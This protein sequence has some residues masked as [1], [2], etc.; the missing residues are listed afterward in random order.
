MPVAIAF[1]GTDVVFSPAVAAALR[2]TDLRT[3]EEVS[4]MGAG[5]GGSEE[6]EAKP[7]VAEDPPAALF[8]LGAVLDAPTLGCSIQA[9]S[10][11]GSRQDLI[12]TFALLAAFLSALFPSVCDSVQDCEP[13]SAGGEHER[14]CAAVA[15]RRFFAPPSPGYV[16]A[17]NM[18][19]SEA[20]RVFHNPPWL[21]P[22]QFFC[23]SPSRVRR[24]WE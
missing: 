8:V 18:G 3:S 9:E 15:A 23:G 24:A 2:T 1:F 6:N 22:F 13:Q 7:P 10:D 11:G 5:G 20:G 4:F 21:S 19:G 17:I 12:A 14:F 16:F